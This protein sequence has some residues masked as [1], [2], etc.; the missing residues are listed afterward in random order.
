MARIEGL[1]LAILILP[2]A[3]Q[4]GIEDRQKCWH[5]GVGEKTG[6]RKSVV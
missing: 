6:D 1:G 5:R 3:W 2:E 4:G